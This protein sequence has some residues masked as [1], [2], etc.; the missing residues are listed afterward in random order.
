MRMSHASLQALSR[1]KL[2]ELA[3][4]RYFARGEA[5]FDEGRVRGLTEY[6]G[7]LMARVAGTEDYRVKL[8]ADGGDIGYSCSCPLGDDGEFCKHCV[9]VGLAWIEGSDVQGKR[10]QIGSATTTLEDVRALLERQ[11]KSHLV[12]MLLNEALENESLRERLLLETARLH[13]ERVNLATY[14]RALKVAIRTG[15]YVAYS[16]T[17]SYARGIRR[18]AEALATLLA[19]GHAA[20]VVELTEYAL[21][22]IEK[23]L[24]YVDDSDG[25]VGAVAFELQELHRHACQQARS[26]PE[27]LARRL[28]AW[29]MRSEWE[30]FGGAVELYA[31]VLGQAGLA[32]YRRLAEAEWARVPALGPGEADV[33]YDGRRVRITQIMKTLARQS[34]DVEALVEIMQRDLSHAYDYLQIAEAY[35][36]AG[37]HDAA[38]DWAE[39]GWNTFAPARDWRLGE[40]IADEYHRRGRHDEALSLMW[41]QFTQSP[42]LEHYRKLHTHAHTDGRAHWSHWRE[43]ALAHLRAATA[44]Q[45]PRGQRAQAYRR[46]P[47]RSELV[48]VLL[49]EKRYDEAWQEA[50]AGGC[51]DDLWLQLAAAREAEHPED[52]LAIYRERIAPLVEL[53]NNPAYEQAIELLRKVRKLMLRLERAREF[54]DYLVTL[55]VAYKR[56]RNFTQ[57]LGTII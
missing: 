34:D 5:Y 7:K 9:A 22:Q 12:E 16:A 56:K 33:E 30:F 36:A 47:D 3:G 6:R 10:G 38:L 43:R 44:D 28:F 46:A 21:A 52:A 48:R 40:F 23:S 49:W 27:A 45:P 18:A 37:K 15:N 55:R 24:G 19:D 35:R 4:E 17:G 8:W 57:L 2:R 14:R 54:D 29:E 41:E 26:E 51:A 50:R 13:P 1:R 20:E 39:R 31:D 11:D 53:T 25:R 42:D 32:E